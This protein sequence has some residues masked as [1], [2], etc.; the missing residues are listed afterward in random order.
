MGLHYQTAGF[1]FLRL[2]PDLVIEL[3]ELAHQS[4][5]SIQIDQM[6]LFCFIGDASPSMPLTCS[7]DIIQLSNG[8][9]IQIEVVLDRIVTIV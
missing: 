8:S 5:P 6:N 3:K 9:I 7:S 1:T 2:K 4:F